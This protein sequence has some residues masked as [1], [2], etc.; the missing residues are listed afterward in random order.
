MED[1]SER[2]KLEAQLRQAQKLEGIGQLAGGVAHDFNNIL[3]AIIGY[4]YLAHLN[5]REDDPL[6][7]HIKQILDY[8]EKAASITKSLLAFSRK[9]TTHL[10]HFNLN[11]LVSNFQNFLLRLVPENIEIQTRCSDQI[12]PVFVDQVQ[13]EQVILNLAT[14]A[15]D[16]MP[17]GGRFV[18]KTNWVEL[19]D[20]FIKTHGY[21][22]TGSYAE[23]SVTDTGIGMDQQTREKIFDPFFTTKEQGKGTG[24]GMAIVYGIIKNHN[25][26]VNVDS[27]VG[28]GTQFKILLPIARTVTAENKK[29]QESPLFKGGTETV[30]IAED[31]PGIRDLITTILTEHGYNV[32]SAADGEEAISQFRNN[33][34]KVALVMLDGIMPKKS[35]KEVFHEIKILQPEVKV[36]FMSGYSENMLDFAEVKE[37]G[38]HFLQKPVLPSNILRKVREVLDQENV[39]S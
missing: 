33:K 23:I 22:K 5:M 34:E 2:R 19:N 1:I 17:Q 38:V 28:R 29:K 39:K 31:D 10:T 7:N 21:G 30:L 4:A 24:L 16:A 6:R 8:S 20:E 32:I 12:L 14:N 13:I 11:D 9:Q 25:G 15:R 35:G 37:K 36:I 26:Y 18:I 3:T 27:E